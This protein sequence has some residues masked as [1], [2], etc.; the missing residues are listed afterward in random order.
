MIS[1]TD[2]VLGRILGVIVRETSPEKVIL[3]GSRARGTA[4]S[5][6][7]VD[8]LIIESASFGTHRSRIKEMARIERALRGILVPTDIL[9]YSHDEYERW[10]DSPVHVIS[11][12]LREGKVLYGRS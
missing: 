10:K 1:V 12:A 6:S 4:E 7:D 11:R 2:E 3:F 9:V 5:E 8:I